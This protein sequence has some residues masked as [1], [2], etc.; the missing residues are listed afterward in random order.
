MAVTPGLSSG[1]AMGMTQSAT[2]MPTTAPTV[3]PA[4]GAG[5]TDSMLGS[6]GLL[7]VPGAGGASPVARRRL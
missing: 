7:A 2:T 1:R 6:P 4:I 5:L 3:G